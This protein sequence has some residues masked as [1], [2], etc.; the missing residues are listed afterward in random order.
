MVESLTNRELDILELLQQ[1]LQNKEISEKLFISLET[2]KA[3]LKNIF[4]KLNA[5]NRR[6]AVSRAKGLGI[7]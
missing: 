7:L 3:H 1:R 2:V 6:E 4:Q 5:G